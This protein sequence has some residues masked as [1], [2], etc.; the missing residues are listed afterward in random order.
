MHGVLTLYTTT[1]SHRRFDEDDRALTEQLARRSAVAIQNA[2]LYRDAQAAEAR[3]RGLFEG[4]N[5]GIIMFDPDGTCVDVNPAM[6][7]M[8][9]YDRTE[10]VGRAVTVV[11][12]GGPW[13][14]EE[15]ERLRRDGQWRGRIRVAAQERIGDAGRIVDH[16]SASSP[17]G[18]SMSAS[19]AMS[20]SGDDSNN[21]RR[22]S[23]PLWPTT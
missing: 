18:Q 8:V 7:A 12:C 11:A 10:L 14:G 6:M 9:G 16:V 5:D 17:L 1:I 21:S 15:G 4:T 3:Y 20:P 13:A 22:S 2:R 19:C 23:S